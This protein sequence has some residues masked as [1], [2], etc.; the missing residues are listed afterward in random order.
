M[1]CRNA[2]SST[3][4]LP[5][6]PPALPI[7]AQAAGLGWRGGGQA[8][9]P[10]GAPSLSERRSPASRG[11]AVTEKGLGPRC[12]IP[13]ALPVAPDAG[14]GRCSASGRSSLLP[15][16]LAVGHV[17][18]RWR[19]PYPAPRSAPR[20]AAARDRAARAS[21]AQ[22]RGPPAPFGPKCA[23]EK[24]ALPQVLREKET[25]GPP[26]TGSYVPEHPAGGNAI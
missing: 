2:P 21:P 15:S 24:Q 12:L 17:Q 26:R 1:I 5:V 11:A 22:G 8:G 3:G 20:V 13:A 10:G 6:S 18:E 14:G 23:T 9:G 4:P 25:Q 19:R 16:V 7:G